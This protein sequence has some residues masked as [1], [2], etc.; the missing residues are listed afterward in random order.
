MVWSSGSSTSSIF[1]PY[2]LE[3]VSPSNDNETARHSGY[4]GANSRVGVQITIDVINRGIVQRVFEPAD[5]TDRRAGDG[6]IHHR[7]T[8]AC[9]SSSAT[10]HPTM[11][12]ATYYAQT[13]ASQ[14]AKS[15][16]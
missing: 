5:H 16:L 6:L 4:V 8:A 15:Q 10:S 13:Q 11:Y 2:A 12:E 7:T 1:L 3:A 14:S 9:T